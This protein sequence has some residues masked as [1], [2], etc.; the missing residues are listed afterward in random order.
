MDEKALLLEALTG[1]P[2]VSIGM[3]NSINRELI[4]GNT[5]QGNVILNKN[6][7]IKEIKQLANEFNIP[8]HALITLIGAESDFRQFDNF[9]KPLVNISPNSSAAGLGQVT[10]T[11]ASLYGHDYDKLLIDW[12]YNLRVSTII[13]NAGYSHP[14]NK[15]IDDLRIRAA[16]AYGMYHDGFEPKEDKD[17]YKRQ[18][19][20]LTGSSY[21]IRYLSYY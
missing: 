3:I 19:R 2:G 18:P 11:S 9:G 7:I 4:S 10:R 6:E 8:S 20:G 14:W 1:V 12:K 21:E 16:R 17:L 5:G 15:N 13:Y